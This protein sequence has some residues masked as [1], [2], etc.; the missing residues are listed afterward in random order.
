MRAVGDEG[1]GQEAFVGARM[2][3]P[4]GQATQIF[5]GLPPLLQL[6]ADHSEAL[7][8]P[9]GSTQSPE[10][11]QISTANRRKNSCFLGNLGI[12]VVLAR[13]ITPHPGSGPGASWP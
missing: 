1:E 13:Q 8:W 5:E 3:D 9:D 12:V 4:E 6:D 11:I 10:L 7:P 2:I